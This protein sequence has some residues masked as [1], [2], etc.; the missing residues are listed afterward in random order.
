LSIQPTAILVSEIC[1][2]R[3]AVFSNN[4]N[5]NNRLRSIDDV[6]IY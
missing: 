2:P 4:N 1:A 6:L 5:N 3:K